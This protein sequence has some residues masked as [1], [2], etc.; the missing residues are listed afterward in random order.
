MPILCRPAAFPFFYIEPQLAEN[1]PIIDK[2][3]KKNAPITQFAPIGTYF[4]HITFN[5]G[6]GII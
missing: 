2:F 1:K 6:W 3:N 4:T 5:A